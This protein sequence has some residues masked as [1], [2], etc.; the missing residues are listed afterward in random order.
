MLLA[1]CTIALRDPLAIPVQLRL[2][3]TLPITSAGKVDKVALRRIEAMRAV[4][5]ALQ[6][7]GISVSVAVDPEAGEAVQL[8][9]ENIPRGRRPTV[10]RVM[11]QFSIAWRY[12]DGQTG[13]AVV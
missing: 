7:A 2:L 5:E 4:R 3:P 11:E 13:R 8:V 6:G 1:H 12:G 9:I 10:V